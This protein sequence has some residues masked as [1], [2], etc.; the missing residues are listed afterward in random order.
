MPRRSLR[1]AIRTPARRDLPR[2]FALDCHAFLCIIASTS[3]T[4]F[5]MAS[6]VALASRP[7]N[8]RRRKCC[9]TS[10][11]VLTASWPAKSEARVRR[12]QGGCRVQG[13]VSDGFPDA[14][15]EER[16]DILEYGEGGG[17]RRRASGA[18]QYVRV[19]TIWERQ[20]LSPRPTHV[21]G[22]HTR[23]GGLGREEGIERRISKTLRLI[24]ASAPGF[25]DAAITLSK[26]DAL[27]S[28]GDAF[29]ASPASIKAPSTCMRASTADTRR[30]P[31][32]APPP[33]VV[34][35]VPKRPPISFFWAIDR[36]KKMDLPSRCS[37]NF[38]PSLPATLANTRI[39]PRCRCVDGFGSDIA[40]EEGA[41]ARWR[42][43]RG[44]VGRWRR[45]WR[46]R[47]Q[48]WC[49]ARGVSLGPS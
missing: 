34:N 44:A 32:A 39:L 10:D 28:S 30:R 6:R 31:R 41:V 14:R 45:R 5:A 27:G 36:P 1:S 35:P 11:R 24:G 18:K 16:A 29:A 17:R 48:R 7:T 46:R 25:V 42:G 15:V 37:V 38:A 22:R 21:I 49:P 23:Q 20:A 3:R 2:P 47:C 19:N 26:R 12:A 4:S 33:F 13:W 8:P 43:A 9:S 40:A